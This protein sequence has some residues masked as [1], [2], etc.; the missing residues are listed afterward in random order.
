MNIINK[1]AILLWF[2]TFVVAIQTQI[3]GRL[4]IKLSVALVVLVVQKILY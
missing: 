2:L 3:T 1:S 4:N